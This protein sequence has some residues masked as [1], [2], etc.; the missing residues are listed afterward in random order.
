MP[1][2]PET[3]TMAKPLPGRW[4]RGTFIIF[5][6]LL[7]VL[8]AVYIVIVKCNDRDS[9][10]KLKSFGLS[11]RPAFTDYVQLA[12]LSPKYIPQT[13]KHR[14]SPGRLVVVGDVHGM[15]HSL[16]ELLEEL[17]FDKKHDHLILAGDMVSKGP[18]SAGVVD[19]AMSLGAT[20]IRGNHE[21]RIILVAGEMKG[22]HL[23]TQFPN[24]NEPD[25]KKQD[26]LE[27]ESFSH[28]NYKV[29]RLVRQLGEK[30]IKWLADCPVIL[31]VGDLGGMGEVVVVHAGLAPGLELE[32]QDPVTV[33]N[34]RTIKDGVPTDQRDGKPWMKVWNDYQKT[35]P[36]KDRSTVI[37][38]HDSRRGL[39]MDKYSMGIDTGCRRGG[40]LSAVVIEGGQ[41]GHTHKL[42]QV[43]CKN[44]SSE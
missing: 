24:P 12:D 25:N 18:D 20:C 1:L 14:T 5:G 28:G 10:M 41:S 19:F 29:R 7:G 33:M 42:V 34:M 3:A 44:A 36:K 30:R 6:L 23:D 31:R 22:K 13:G 39:Q 32:R 4:R 37:Y 38:G 27:E 2:L 43:N 17:N 11:A 8:W 16:V 40:K 35:L 21:D 15:R 26:S 9:A